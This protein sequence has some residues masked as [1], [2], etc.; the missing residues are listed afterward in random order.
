MTMVCLNHP[1]RE[2][3]CKCAAC[4]KPVCEECAVRYDEDVYC[5]V[6]CQ[7]RGIAAKDRSSFI[8]DD[9]A[10]NN[11]KRR[12][13][14]F[15]FLIIAAVIAAAAYYYYS[16]NKEEIHSKVSTHVEIFEDTYC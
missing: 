3:V 11:R 4:G 16:Q 15:I 8:I 2:A 14:G 5:S 6:E 13:K 7:E 12:R 9:T 1:D 10:K